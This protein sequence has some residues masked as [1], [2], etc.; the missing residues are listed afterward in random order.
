M[1]T[2][3]NYYD[4]MNEYTININK[5]NQT[6]FNLD[7]SDG[8][9]YTSYNRTID[10][11][12]NGGFEG[13]GYITITIDPPSSIATIIDNV[14]NYS[15]VGNFSL[16]VFK[17]G[18]E[19]YN[20]ASDNFTITIY[21]SIIDDDI[22]D[23][24]QI[25]NN[26][27]SDDTFDISVNAGD[28]FINLPTYEGLYEGM[29]IIIDEGANIEERKKITGFGSVIV[30]SPFGNAHTDATIKIDAIPL[31]ISINTSI[32][33]SDNNTFIIDIS[34]GIGTG[35]I[36]LSFEDLDGGTNALIFDPNPVPF[37]SSDTTCT[38]SYDH[39]GNYKI[40]ATKDTLG[41]YTEQTTSGEF[42]IQKGPQIP[43][44]ID[45]PII[46]Y[47]RN[48]NQITIPISGGSNGSNYTI[49]DISNTN[50]PYTIS[51]ESIGNE[52]TYGNL[53]HIPDD[54]S[55]NV[56]FTVNLSGGANF[57]DVSINS[58]LTLV[59]SVSY[60]R[61]Q[62]VNSDVLTDDSNYTFGQVANVY[63][64]KSLVSDGFSVC[65]L[66][67]NGKEYV[68]FSTKGFKFKT[69]LR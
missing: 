50:Q 38:V 24:T 19:T 11:S 36:N 16:H 64:T 60:W 48:P 22:F 66:L 21:P 54:T 4:K 7:V 31:S 67:D 63:D 32:D 47:A 20:D 46:E 9:V 37:F 12:V 13:V 10:V 2:N 56:I 57:L 23:V 33:F 34:G 45:T 29:Y 15:D 49:S 17:H 8:Y 18:N 42:V 55:F 58:S 62:N 27:N 28:N 1:D 65:Q 59:K 26:I 41:R 5:I 44:E 69:C 6:G 3:H 53:I 68:D 25:E 43:L 30:D 40:I 14:V 52:I 51:F 61:N 35:N 39:I